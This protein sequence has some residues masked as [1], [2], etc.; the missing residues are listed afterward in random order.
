MTPT[1]ASSVSIPAR[2]DFLSI[3]LP[4]M[5]SSLKE[6]VD[7]VEVR[8]RNQLDKSSVRKTETHFGC[9]EAIIPYPALSYTWGVEPHSSKEFHG[10][11][12]LWT[13]PCDLDVSV[14]EPAMSL[15]NSLKEQRDSGQDETPIIFIAHGHGGLVLSRALQNANATLLDNIYGVLF[16]STPPPRRRLDNLFLTVGQILCY[17][18]MRGY[19]ACHGFPIG[20]CVAASS[21]PRFGNSTKLTNPHWIPP[22]SDITIEAPVEIRNFAQILLNLFVQVLHLFLS[23]TTPLFVCIAMAYGILAM[24]QYHI[25]RSDQA[26]QIFLL[27]SLVWGIWATFP[28]RPLEVGQTL[29][30]TSL[31]LAISTT[32]LSSLGLHWFWRNLFG[33]RK[34][35]L[36]VTLEEWIQDACTRSDGPR[37]I[38]YERVQ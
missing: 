21:I 9:G 34:S 31:S 6:R 36:D 19:D 22:F 35:R 23:P 4:H 7:L 5:K 13:I 3:R 14:A 28:S 38:K 29:Q 24:S 10:H 30:V 17:A 27:I 20:S 33:T 15:L 1:H 12:R 2:C 25:N 16:V 18:A 32:L 37:H 26:Q 11:E 8:I